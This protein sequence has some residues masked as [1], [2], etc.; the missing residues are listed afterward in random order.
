MALSLQL[1]THRTNPCAQSFFRSHLPSSASFCHSRF[2]RLKNRKKRK[3]EKHCTLFSKRSGST[4]WN[5]SPVELPSWAT[6]ADRRGAP[7]PGGIA[8]GKPN[9][10]GARGLKNSIRASFPRRK[11]NRHAPKDLETDIEGAKFRT[12][13]MP[14]TQRGGLQ[15]LDELGERLRFETV[16]DFEDWIARLRAFPVLMDQSIALMQE[17]AREKVIWPK[18][19]LERV[20]G[21]IDKQLVSKPEESPFFK[22][23]TKFPDAQPTDRNASQAA[24]EA[25]APSPSLLSELKNTSRVSFTAPEQVGVWQMPNARVL[26]P[27]GAPLYHHDLTPDNH[28]K[29]QRVARI[30]GEMES[31]RERSDSRDASGFFTKPSDRSSSTRLRGSGKPTRDV[32]ADRSELVKVFK[33]FPDSYGVRPPGQDRADTTAYYNQPADGSRAASIF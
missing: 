20:P 16:K 8:N 5:K 10:R 30:K 1:A 33:P 27:S 32:E 26:R 18:I 15:T 12:Y 11:I 29:G 23:F 25:I 7:K 4:K 21:Q 24:Q 2:P 19:V 13:L 3:P 28:D 14:I 17:G 6:A 31:I 9:D 22:P